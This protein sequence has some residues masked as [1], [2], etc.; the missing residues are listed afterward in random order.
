MKQSGTLRVVRVA[1]WF[2]QVLAALIIIFVPA[3]RGPGL[4][5]VMVAAMALSTY[6]ETRQSGTKVY[7]LTLRQIHQRIAS[8]QIRTNPWDALPLILSIVAFVMYAFDLP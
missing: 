2:V 7:R 5:G 6:L 8:G 1:G 4:L 3:S